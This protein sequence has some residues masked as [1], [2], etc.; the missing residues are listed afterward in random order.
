MIF[1]KNNMYTK[2]APAIML[3]FALLSHGEDVVIGVEIRS[4]FSD[5]QKL[6]ASTN[7]SA[8][9]PDSIIVNSSIGKI[10][11]KPRD[12]INDSATLSCNPDLVIKYSN[13]GNK[14]TL[15]KIDFT[16]SKKGLKYA[17]L[18]YYART[19]PDKVTVEL[20]YDSGWGFSS[21]FGSSHTNQVIAQLSKP[22]NN[23]MHFIDIKFKAANLGAA[24]I[25]PK[26]LSEFNENYVTNNFVND[27][28]TS[29]WIKVI[30]PNN[31]HYFEYAA[32]LNVSQSTN[33][34]LLESV[35]DWDEEA[36]LIEVGPGV[37]FCV[38]DENN[39]AEINDSSLSHDIDGDNIPSYV[40]LYRTFTNPINPDSDNDELGDYQ[41]V[42][43]TNI[44]LRFSSGDMVKHIETCPLWHD[45]DNDGL[46]DG[47]EVYAKYPYVVDGITS[48]YTTDPTSSDTDNDG[49]TDKYDPHPLSPCFTPGAENLSADWISFWQN[50]AMLVGI[51]V[52]GINDPAADSDGDGIT[53][54]SEMLN[55]TNPIFSNGFHKVVFEPD[56]LYLGTMDNVVTAS[57]SATFFA[58]TAI[59]GKVH[60]SK[61][62]LTPVLMMDALSVLWPPFLQKRD[63]EIALTFVSDCFQ[64][65]DFILIADQSDF[66]SSIT[67]TWIKVTDQFGE[68]NE[69][70]NV[71]FNS[72]LNDLSPSVPELILPENNDV[73]QLDSS[74]D[75]LSVSF[76]NTYNFS[77]TESTDP[78]GENVNYILKLYYN[79]FEE[80]IA[81]TNEETAMSLPIADYLT[82]TG[83][84]YW[85]VAAF[86]NNGNTRSSVLRKFF[87]SSPKDSDND[88]F[89]DDFELRNGSDPNNADSIPLSI[90]L[91]NRLPDGYVDRDYYFLLKAKGGARRPFYWHLEKNNSA[92]PGLN[93]KTN[94][95]LC[96]TP[97]QD[98]N[99][100][101]KISVFDGVRFETKILNITINPKRTGLGVEAGKGEL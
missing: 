46:T 50:I 74:N 7:L 95:E 54:L 90:D 62:D 75:F 34:F 33:D 72:G 79:A 65:T 45:T 22:L 76:T 19:M 70:L 40:E 36:D 68:Y 18:N 80:N 24:N 86:D 51:N 35:P 44:T 92:P 69:K 48:H 13:G 55:K 28:E 81:F 57:F 64:K 15:Q 91:Q 30:A 27:Y 41:E 67:Q 5:I 83:E 77:W 14:E 25:P 12:F 42:F 53:N 29:R 84:Y 94:G 87:V 38:F 43:G 3:A 47:Q 63:D 2:I 26:L 23:S 96:G 101:M 11:I 10:K 32:S 58:S 31:P 66:S 52:S 20:L 73:L 89:Y 71:I 8:T 37:S 93:L 61:L 6:A 21:L 1:R 60:M 49:L 88:G 99:Y 4:D 59:T 16:K 39:H 9:V 98:G 85:R 78:E 100:S 82:E 17:G 56:T 97:T